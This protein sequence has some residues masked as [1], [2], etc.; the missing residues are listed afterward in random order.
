MTP[1]GTQ[2]GN[3]KMAKSTKRK[4]SK[5]NEKPKGPESKDRHW[6]YQQSVQSPGEHV[7]F[8]DRVYKL[9]NDRPPLSMKEDFCG[10]AFLSCE[11][12]TI[13][14]ENTAI[15]VDLDL[16]TLD[17][18]REHNVSPLDDTDQAKVTLLHENVLSVTDPKVDVVAALNFSYFIF[19]TRDEVRAYFEKARES[20]NAGGVFVLD[21]FGGWE[22]YMEET[23][24]TRDEGFTY[25][26]TQTKY[27]PITNDTQ[28]QIQFKFHG[29]GGIKPAF[30]YDWRLWSLPEIKELLVEAGFASVDVY[31]EQIDEDTNEGSGEF[32]L[33]KTAENCPGWIA[34]LVCSD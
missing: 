6:L 18:G 31:W 34:M 5:K 33:V 13:R 17:W 8:F 30:V 10:T 9:K 2:T 7:E 24:Y 15:G 4:K 14:P 21:I 23:D 20:L 19:K 12:V 3:T 25:V 26:W 11:W 1:S 27:D 32:K 22:S 29:G 28:F 16:E